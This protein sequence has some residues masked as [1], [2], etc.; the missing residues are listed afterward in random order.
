MELIAASNCLLAGLSSGSHCDGG[1]TLSHVRSNLL[2]DTDVCK[3]KDLHEED[4]FSCA[5]QYSARAV[6]SSDF[7]EDEI[8]EVDFDAWSVKDIHK[9]DNCIDGSGAALAF[10]ADKARRSSRREYNLIMGL[11]LMKEIESDYK[12]SMKLSPTKSP[13]PSKRAG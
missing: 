5:D 9:H 2:H 13:L 12:S 11:V 7:P 3:M 10:M 6:L 4:C 8:F 1:A